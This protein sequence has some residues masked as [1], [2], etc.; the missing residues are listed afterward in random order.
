VAAPELTEEARQQLAGSYWNE[1]AE[2]G[3]RVVSEDGGLQ[4]RNFEREPGSG[5]ERFTGP[6]VALTPRGGP[7]SFVAES[8]ARYGFPGRGGM[9]ERL[10]VETGGE[11]VA[12]GPEG[13]AESRAAAREA[14]EAPAASETASAP[15]DLAP[16]RARPWPQFRGP[17]GSGI[18]DEQ[19]VPL[20]WNAAEVSERAETANAFAYRV[21]GDA[22]VVVFRHIPETWAVHHEIGH[23]MG[24]YHP[25]GGLRPSHMWYSG[26]LEPPHFTE[27][28]IF[29]AQAMYARPPGN[30]DVDVDPPG[31]VIGGTA[32]GTDAGAG[33]IVCFFP[34]RPPHRH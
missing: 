15:G 26:E 25:L 7:R 31:F 6:P 27:W 34:E 11:T 9:V 19:G 4:A 5:N 32:A 3:V 24:L 29:H 22:N 20:R 14:A 17:R 2:R 23:V 13:E 21:G 28:D 12:Y 1:T 18:A 33:P 8:G 30:T 10:I 16:I